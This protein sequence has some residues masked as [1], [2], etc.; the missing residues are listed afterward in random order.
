[1]QNTLRMKKNLNKKNKILL[2]FP[3]S[4]QNQVLKIAQI[5]LRAVLTNKCWHYNSKLRRVASH[6]IDKCILKS[7]KKEFTWMHFFFFPSTIITIILI[8]HLPAECSQT[9]TVCLTSVYPSCYTFLSPCDPPHE[10][11]RL[12][13]AQAA[14]LCWIID[15]CQNCI[16]T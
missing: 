1:M 3:T 4:K 13:P 8:F 6:N 12:C 14:L 2:R 16:F 10:F 7:H 11:G 9:P 15:K 5:F